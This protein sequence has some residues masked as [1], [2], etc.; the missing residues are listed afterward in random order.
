MGHLYSVLWILLLY[1]SDTLLVGPDRYCL[2]T[3][4]VPQDL[5]QDQ[6]DEEY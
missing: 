3:L 6:P 2:Q 5:L 1:W 4:G